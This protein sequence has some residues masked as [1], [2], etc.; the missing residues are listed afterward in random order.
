MNAASS[1]LDPTI[2]CVTEIALNDQGG[3][4]EWV[5]L[6]P[7]GY[8]VR[9]KDGR[10]WINPA[11]QLVV[12]AFDPRLPLPV[13]W[14]HAT[15]VR[16]PQG[17]DAP[18]AAWIEELAIRD[19]GAIWG[20][21]SW[22]PQGA[23]QV[24]EKQYRFLSPVFAFDRATG[25]IRRL[26]SAALTN[27]PNLTLTALNRQSAA[28]AQGLH[29]D[30]E[31]TTLDIAALR[32][33]LGLPADASDDAILT[34]A[35][36]ATATNRAQPT[37]STDKSVD[38][39]VYAPRSDLDTALNR[40]TTAEAELKTLKAEKAEQEINTA[41]SAAMDAGKIVPA[42]ADHYRAIC[43]EEGG[44]ARFKELEKTMPVIAGAAESRAQNR[45]DTA[46]GKTSAL[47]DEE[48]A[49]CRAL[50]QDEATFRSG[51]SQKEV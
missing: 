5:E 21:T 15:E 33:A 26:L 29:R 23:R 28:Q 47:T 34:A 1:T 31:E 46:P 45:A 39:T 9:G 6:I 48:R 19:G 8:D 17:L 24:T 14:E 10:A 37:G 49:V 27:T 22:T 42:S 44:L 20:R 43:R 35:R 50:G 4:P 3:A 25:A 40:A 30:H 7:P 13:D 11:P 18:A 12:D 38:L 2:T 16:A 41:I 36:D 51:Q 32:T